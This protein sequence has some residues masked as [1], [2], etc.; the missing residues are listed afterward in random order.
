MSCAASCCRRSR[1]SALSTA[2]MTSRST[3]KG[4]LTQLGPN[5]RATDD[6]ALRGRGDLFADAAGRANGRATAQPGRRRAPGG[7]SDRDPVLVDFA[8]GAGQHFLFRGGRAGGSDRARGH[9]AGGAGRHPHRA[10][11]ADRRTNSCCTTQS[12]LV[13]AQHDA[14]LAEF[15][16]ASAVGRLI[17]P[18]LNLPVRLYDMEQHYKEVKDKWI[19]FRGGLSE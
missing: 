7:G 2:P 10:R 13:T 18:E 3:F 19:G 14:A 5:H 16:L 11:R 6:A 15:N 1:S 8:S 12:Q 17:A 4:T 9:A